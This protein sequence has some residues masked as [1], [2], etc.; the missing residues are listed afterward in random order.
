M[1]RSIDTR[2]A[3]SPSSH[4][5]ARR[6]LRGLVLTAWSSFFAWL[7]FSGEMSRYLGPRTYWVVPFGA[8]MLG[9]AAVMHVLTLRTPRRSAR[10]SA[11]EVLGAAVLVVPLL[12]VATVPSA[13]LGALAASR[14]TTGGTLIAEGLA[15]GAEPIENPGFKEIA[16]AEESQEY[17]DAI[18]LTEGMEVNLT[19]FVDDSDEAPEGTLIL[20]RFYVSCCAADAIPFSVAVDPN[21][22]S[23]AEAEPDSWMEA[24]GALERRG[25]RF[26]LVATSLEAVSEPKSPYLY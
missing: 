21:G 11:L 13:D 20:T 7:W 18:G 15:G 6:A 23:S 9:V 26:V 2:P 12:A 1:S 10:P 25:D 5:D 22:Q 14:K 17:A 8:V 24:E 16:Y 19:G 3:G 4:L